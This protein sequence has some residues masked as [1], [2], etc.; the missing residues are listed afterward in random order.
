MIKMDP[1]VKA[2]AEDVQKQFGLSMQCYEG[3]HQAQ[4]ALEQIK[5]YR[6]QLKGLGKK[7]ATTPEAKSPSSGLGD[8]IAALDK[9]LAGIEGAEVGPYWM[10]AR[11]GNPR[12]EPSLRLAR[13]QLTAVLGILQG[14][15]AAPTTQVIDGCRSAQ[16][17]LTS[18]LERWQTL[19]DQDVKTLNEKLTEAKLPALTP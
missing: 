17:T 1:R 13:S 10:F 6:A 4:K 5:K 18:L 9:K 14:A 19:H 15:D 3:L 12:Q 7:G 8:E 16:K 2:S 11:W